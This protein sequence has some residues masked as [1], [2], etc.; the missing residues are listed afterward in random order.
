MPFVFMQSET[1][2]REIC[3][4][5]RHDGMDYDLTRLGGSAS[6]SVPANAVKAAK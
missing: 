3:Q 5:E 2:V 6:L 4:G 1:I